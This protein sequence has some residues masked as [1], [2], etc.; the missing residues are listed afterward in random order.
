VI[1]E[2][3]APTAAAASPGT[4]GSGDQHGP[5]RRRGDS[6]RGRAHRRDGGPGVAACGPFP[7]AFRGGARRA[8]PGSPD[9]DGHQAEPASPASSAADDDRDS[10]D[11]SRLFRPP[12]RDANGNSRRGTAGVRF[13]ATRRPGC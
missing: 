3:N 8:A 12:G 7:A 6:H 5:A 2:R 9:R 13:T 1:E 4:P 11:F 10:E